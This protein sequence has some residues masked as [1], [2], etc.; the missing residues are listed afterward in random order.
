MPKILSSLFLV[1][2]LVFSSSP[3]FSQGLNIDGV[4]LSVVSEPTLGFIESAFSL[5]TA[6]PEINLYMNGDQYFE[7]LNR[8]PEN[9]YTTY[10]V[11]NSRDTSYMLFCWLTA[12]FQ[13]V[14]SLHY[15]LR[16]RPMDLDDEAFSVWQHLDLSE[17]QFHLWL[18]FYQ[19]ARQN[20]PGL[21]LA[22]ASHGG[23]FNYHADYLK[24]A[25]DSTF[26]EIQSFGERGKGF[27]NFHQ[28]IILNLK[29][30]GDA[31][32]FNHEL[33]RY[34]A[35]F[36]ALGSIKAKPQHP[37][38]IRLSKPHS[39]YQHL[40]AWVDTND[41]LIKVDES[42][43]LIESLSKRVNYL[44]LSPKGRLMAISGMEHGRPHN[45]KEV[46]VLGSWSQDFNPMINSLD[47]LLQENQLQFNRDSLRVKGIGKALSQ[48]GIDPKAS[49]CRLKKIQIIKGSAVQNYYFNT[50]YLEI[51]DKAYRTQEQEDY[52]ATWQILDS[53]FH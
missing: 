40:Q 9:L 23:C 46:Q 17:A 39:A 16:D 47:S 26:Y 6:N 41:Y 30:G 13:P 43:I 45:Y 25:S 50:C 42:E 48:E 44:V 52:L 38:Q 2:L 4:P 53:F 1:L 14:I 35:E 12:D 24:A 34:F 31:R 22:F 37:Q 7:F 11:S 20:F 15:Y 8:L 5:R 21:K 49:S 33:R 19:D 32:L 10:V 27:E 29:N 28:R 51:S 36:Y 3:S 18:Q